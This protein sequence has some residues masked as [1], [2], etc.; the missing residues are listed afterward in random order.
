M[1]GFS[2]SRSWGSCKGTEGFCS[3]LI[4]GSKEI[5]FSVLMHSGS[6][7]IKLLVKEGSLS[8]FMFGSTFTLFCLEDEIRLI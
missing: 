3:N 4:W 2:G 1:I 5:F 6:G 8:D 7:L